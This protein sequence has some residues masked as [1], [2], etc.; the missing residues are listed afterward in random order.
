MD[1]RE[2]RGWDLG[3]KGPWLELEETER[4]GIKNSKARNS[5]RSK[6]STNTK[7][8]KDSIRSE[9]GGTNA[10]NQEEQCARFREVL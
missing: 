3:Y 7:G 5:T 9:G 10:R 1:W 2:I 4:K 6:G 8:T